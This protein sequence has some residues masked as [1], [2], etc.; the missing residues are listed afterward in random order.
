MWYFFIVNMVKGL[1][2]LVTLFLL[3]QLKLLLHSMQ[4]FRS[5]VCLIYISLFDHNLIL[6]FCTLVCF[7]CDISL[8]LSPKANI[9]VETARL[10][11]SVRPSETLRGYQL[12][13]ICIC[14]VHFLFNIIQALYMYYILFIE[15][16]ILPT[17]FH[18]MAMLTIKMW[19][20]LYG[21]AGPDP[22]LVLFYL[23]LHDLAFYVF[24][25]AVNICILFL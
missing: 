1:I 11:P 16:Y 17:F 9:C 15:L 13:V 18:K 19:S 20:V 2:L 24:N 8:P 10:R 6:P 21:D 7:I 14:R 25:I 4:L 3:K 12:C 22:T 23:G 5:C